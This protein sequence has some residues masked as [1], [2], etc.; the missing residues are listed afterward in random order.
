MY[1]LKDLYRLC[2]GGPECH[3]GPLM[4]A[5]ACFASVYQGE[6]SMKHASPRTVAAAVAVVAAL[7]SL[8]ACG[9][10][11]GTKASGNGASGGSTPASPLAALRAVVTNTTQA[12]SA[13]V[14]ETTTIAPMTVTMNGTQDWS[15]GSKGAITLTVAGKSGIST[16]Q[17]GN[18]GTMQARYTPDAMYI[19]MGP[20][21]A[22]GD[23]GKPWIKYSYD[24]LAKQFGPTGAVMKSQFQNDNP[25]LSVQLLIASGDVKSLGSATVDGTKTT[26]YE[27]TLDVNKL[28]GTAPGLDKAT[29]QGLKAQL[30]AQGVTSD[31]ID[32]WVDGKSL[33]VKKVE[34]M[35]MKSGTTTTTAHYSDYGVAVSVT[36][37]PAA[38][39]IDS[40][41]LPVQLGK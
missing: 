27:G 17:L 26:H 18:N 4:R 3:S 31:H 8:S 6:D 33:L 37:P 5:I 22:M 12:K 9:G 25:T 23:G 10:H 40:A 38:Q 11:S 34:K 13:K 15:S 7:G 19:N 39:T 21:M 29:V 16:A 32:L 35:V 24:A 20:E 28:L 2:K 14:S 30:T 41:Q 36:P 1:D